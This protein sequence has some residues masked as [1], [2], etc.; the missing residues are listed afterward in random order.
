MYE[1]DEGAYRKEIEV[2]CLRRSKKSINEGLDTPGT[3]VSYRISENKRIRITAWTV[4]Q[5]QLSTYNVIIY[6]FTVLILRK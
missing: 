3:G 4:D 5:D 6:I 2:D 1:T